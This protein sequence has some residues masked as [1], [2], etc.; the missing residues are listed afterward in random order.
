MNTKCISNY[1]QQIIFREQYLSVRCLPCLALFCG[2]L[3]LN[4]NKNKPMSGLVPKMVC[5]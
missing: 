1:T 2:P 5:G 4:E 3:N